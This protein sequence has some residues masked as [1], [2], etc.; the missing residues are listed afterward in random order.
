MALG[1]HLTQPLHRDVGQARH[2][3][4]HRRP[5]PHGNALDGVEV[6]HRRRHAVQRRQLRAV[7]DGLVGAAV[8][9]GSLALGTIAL[10]VVLLRPR[11]DR[12]TR[13]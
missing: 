9:A 5:E 8:A 6:L 3:V 12:D 7:D 4:E 11:D 2:E 10:V 1:V 13:A